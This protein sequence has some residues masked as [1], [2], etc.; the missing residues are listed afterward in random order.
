M[1][2]Y[3]ADGSISSGFLASAMTKGLSHA[4]HERHLLNG[5]PTT[6]PVLAKGAALHAW[7]TRDETVTVWAA[8]G[9]KSRAGRK[10]H[11][12]LDLARMRDVDVLLTQ[13]G[14]NEC[15]RSSASLT[16]GDTPK[17]KEIIAMFRAWKSWPEISHRWVPTDRDGEPV[18]GAVC[19]IRQ[20][21]VA[22]TP[23]G[24]WVSVQV[25]TTAATGITANSWW[26]FWHRWYRRNA[27]FYRAGIRHL[28]AGEALKEIYVVARLAEPYPW[29]WF[30][31][32]DR[33]DELDAIWYDE[34]I[35]E[36]RTIAESLARGER[37]GL[38]ERGL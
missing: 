36:I 6:E 23:G 27:A 10:W 31:L 12:W 9:C 37:Y 8:L 33:A 26:S 7:L 2:E 13:A 29:T 25:K 18:E 15:E 19:R 20:D 3:L 5:R 32:T 24:L 34:L 1:A 38:E 30:D 4:L 35:P 28:M 17:K 11:R 16:R 22:R 21:L 14:M